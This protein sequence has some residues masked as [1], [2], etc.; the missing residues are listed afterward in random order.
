M[1]L[2]VRPPPRAGVRR[3]RTP[4][5]AATATLSSSQGGG[6]V[7]PSDAGVSVWRSRASSLGSEGGG[8]AACRAGKGEALPAHPS[9]LAHVATDAPLRSQPQG[10]EPREAATCEQR[11]L[12]IGAVAPP[13]SVEAG[14][15]WGGGPSRQALCCNE[16]AT[17][18]PT[19]R[20]GT[21]RGRGVRAKTA[22]YWCDGGA[23][24]QGSTPKGQTQGGEPAPRFLHRRPNHQ[25]EGGVCRRLST[26]SMV[27]RRSP[28]RG[29]CDVR[30]ETIQRG[31]RGVPPPSG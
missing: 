7:A 5:R 17:A 21:E 15:G 14:G 3:S 4:A 23:P 19:R 26:R 28:L 22:L 31:W 8:S 20:K 29:G 13:F 11:R 6:G 16:R 10:V 30:A 9:R 1:R 25:V 27:L 12:C 2:A 24:Q 18:G